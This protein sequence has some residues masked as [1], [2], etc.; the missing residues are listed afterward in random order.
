MQLFIAAP[1]LIYLLYRLKKK[2]LPV[3][4]FLILLSVGWTMF[5]FLY[6]GYT[7][8]IFRLENTIDS[9]KETYFP[10][11]IRMGAWLVG[12]IC[13][14]ILFNLRGKRMSVP[15]VKETFILGLT[16]LILKIS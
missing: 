11:H 2:F 10:T 15:L 13:G 6:Y 4:V 16:E 5:L 14:Y 1:V 3:I 7:S 12:V 9:W 8:Q